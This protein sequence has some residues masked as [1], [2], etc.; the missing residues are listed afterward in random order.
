VVA[1]SLSLNFIPLAEKPY[2]LVVRRTHLDL[3]AMQTL[4]ETL[5]RSH[6]RQEVEAYT[7]YNMRTAGDRL[8]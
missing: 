7:G 6:F 1:R 2:H 3:S 4:L 5:G 8:V